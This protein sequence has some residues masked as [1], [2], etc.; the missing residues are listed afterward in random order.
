MSKNK[1]SSKCKFFMCFFKDVFGV[2]IN[3]ACFAT[4]VTIIS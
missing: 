3:V 4:A 2:G 1:K